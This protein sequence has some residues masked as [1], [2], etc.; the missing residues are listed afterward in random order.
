V[1]AF[2]PGAPYG[3]IGGAAGASQV[4]VPGSPCKRMRGEIGLPIGHVAQTW[5]KRPR[6][7]SWRKADLGVQE[8]RNPWRKAAS[9][10]KRR[11]KSFPAKRLAMQK[12]VGSNPIIRSSR[13][14]AQAGFF[15]AS[16]GIKSGSSAR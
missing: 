7:C 16:S 12:V 1:A 8:P 4:A 6:T 15:V 3:Q 10:V 11:P 9:R 13:S 5:P 2:A 14:P